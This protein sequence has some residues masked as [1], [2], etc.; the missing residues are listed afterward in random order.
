MNDD[1]VLGGGQEDHAANFGEAECGADVEGAENGFD[2]HRCGGKF[3]DQRAE[4]FVNIL[5]RSAGGFFLAFR[6]GAEGAVAENYVAAAIAFD[7]RVARRAGEAGS[8]PS[9]RT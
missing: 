5:K 2:G 4:K 3:S 8:K 1:F 9:M 6:G 7:D